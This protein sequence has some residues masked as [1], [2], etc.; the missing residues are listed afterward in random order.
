MFFARQDNKLDVFQKTTRFSE[1]GA[2]EDLRLL[3]R[4]PENKNLKKMIEGYVGSVWD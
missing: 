3:L 2:T 1:L 4:R